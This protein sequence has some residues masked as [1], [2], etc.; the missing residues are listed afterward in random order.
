MSPYVAMS[1]DLGCYILKWLK[2]PIE[3]FTRE[4][5]CVSEQNM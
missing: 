4:S 3:I 2:R 5:L 1:S